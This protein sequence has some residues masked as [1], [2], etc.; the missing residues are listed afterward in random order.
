M[1]R[2]FWVLLLWLALAW[3]QGSGQAAPVQQGLVLP[4][5]G[6]SGHALAQAVAGGLG[7]APPSLAAILL[8]DMPW[9]GSYD[10]AAG[11]LFTAGGARLAW[12]ISGASW[13]L[14]GQ[15]DP[16]G[17]LRVFLAD[18]GGIRSARFSR[19]ELVLYWAA[20]QTG[21]SP[22]AW[23]LETA[24]NDELAR[25]AQGDLTVQN[26]PLPL[27]Y[28]RAA[29]ALRD[30][31]VASL[32]ITEQLP[33]ELQD[34]WSQ[35]RQ[36]RRPL[37][38]QALVD[39]SERRRTEALN[40]ARKLAEGKVYERLTALLLFRG[41]ED[42]QWGAVARQLTVL[43][44]EMP[45]AWE[46]LSF[47]AF[48]ENNPALA[49][50]ALERAAAL[51][52]E[53]NLYWTNLGWAYYLLGDYARSIRA[54]QRSLK[55]EARAREEY[56]VP[57]YNL[58]LVR[59]LYG[60]FL[61]AREA[62]N[63]ALRVDEGEEFK[64]ALKDLQE[65]SAPQLAFWQGYLAE[66]AGLWEQALE[67]YQSFLQ[68]HPRSPLAAW[69]H[70]AIRQ[71]VG[72]KTSVSLQR[73]MLRADDLEARP[74]T[75]GEAVFPQVNI[76]GVPYLASGT[77]VTRL[78]DAQGQVLQS[79]S[80]AVAVQPLTT[81][82]V[83]TGAA[84]R[85]PAEGTYTLEVLYGA[86]STRLSLT[87]LK[88]SLARQLYTAGVELRNLDNA[89]LLSSAQ[90][91]SPQGEALAIQQ[92]QVALQAAAPRARQI[93]SLSRKLTG[94]P[95]NGQSIAELLEKADEALVRAFL[96]AVVRQPELIGDN[97]VVNSFVGWLQGTER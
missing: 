64:A 96:E 15:V 21:V 82:L 37:A 73:L 11:S 25:L 90:M 97:D 28:Y 39:F 50:E 57:A 8:P 86:A 53:K 1:T 22:G 40:A 2:G 75:A 47:V 81:G 68:N 80:K 27:P 31:G 12:E 67:H 59:A 70:R 14:V 78:L 60:D 66:R 61:G 58:G 43:A 36:N 33:R 91:L 89:P 54:S 45:L 69:A 65:A 48:D 83:L 88:P 51:L 7:V 17:W 76:E 5:A 46:E 19:P 9:Q 85:L 72:A 63:L 94:G 42:K 3:G 87:A 93:P 92:V 41:L 6:P 34:F 52:P 18:A 44:P 49:K 20:R 4:F 23:R 79:A 62:Y 71:M 84:V 35:V 26:T 74:F 24:R 55:L 56:A 29:V 95:Y 13:V 10:L 16:Q 77:L 32:L 38:Y 30:N